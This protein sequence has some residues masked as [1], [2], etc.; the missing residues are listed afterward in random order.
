[1]GRGTTVAAMRWRPTLTNLGRRKPR[2]TW[3]IL[4]GKCVEGR[5]DVS[6]SGAAEGAR[7]ARDGRK[8]VQ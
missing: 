3:I 5:G 1:V 4:W 7:G 2:G 8:L 6:V